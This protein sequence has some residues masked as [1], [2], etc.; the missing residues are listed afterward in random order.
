MTKELLKRIEALEVKAG[1][2]KERTIPPNGDFEMAFEAFKEMLKQNGQYD[3]RATEHF[4]VNDTLVFQWPRSN[5]RWNAFYYAWDQ[6]RQRFEH[7]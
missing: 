6:Q 1:L 5:I 4:F 2:A 7:K 3:K